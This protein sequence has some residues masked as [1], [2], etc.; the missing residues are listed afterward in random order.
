M[1]TRLNVLIKQLKVF[2]FTKISIKNVAD[3]SQL[4]NCRFT[5][6][7]VATTN[8]KEMGHK[9]MYNYKTLWYIPVAVFTD[10]LGTSMAL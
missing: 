6:T 2:W 9:Y 3:K 7:V 4:D 8:T 10:D 5:F 1:I